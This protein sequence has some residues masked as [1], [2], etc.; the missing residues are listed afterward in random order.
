MNKQVK[1]PGLGQKFDQ[2]FTRS[3][4]KDGSFNVK[5]VG[6]DYSFKNTY[7]TLIKISW[8]KFLLMILVFM[9]AINLLFTLMYVFAGV[10]EIEGLSGL[11]GVSLFLNVYYF[12]FQTFT[13]VGYGSIAPSGDVSGMIA[14][15]EAMVGLIS[16][17]M[18]T[19]LLYGRF[20]R[21]TARFQYS[22]N[23]IIAPY[24]KGWSFQFRI[25]NRRSSEIIE[26]EAKVMLSISQKEN[27]ETSRRFYNLDLEID[28]IAFLPLNWTLVHPIKEGS[29]LFKKSVDE[30]RNADLE[31]LILIKGFDDTF[32]QVVH[33]RYSYIF[34]EILWGAKF[35]RP[36]Y[37][38]EDS[39]MILDSNLIDKTEKVPFNMYKE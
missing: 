19:G 24:K 27:G 36:Y 8:I 21:P 34:N 37:I 30:L 9:I 31:F 10:N 11:N 7:Q 4:N 38:N 25:A 32:S 23:A 22:K 3:I 39:D 20:S 15:I 17:A 16:F 12:S 29:P 33:S 2:E 18:V 1:D 28:K 6:F 26:L 13:T 14:S 5:R 35:V